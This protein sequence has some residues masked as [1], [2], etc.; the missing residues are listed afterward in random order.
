MPVT[1]PLILLLLYLTSLAHSQQYLPQIG[2]VPWCNLYATDIATSAD[3]TEFWKVDRNGWSTIVSAYP[4]RP[5]TI[6]KITF[7]VVNGGSAAFGVGLLPAPDYLRTQCVGQF[8]NSVSLN[9]FD[10]DKF[11]YGDGIDYTTT[12]T[13]G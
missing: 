6:T 1:T 3:T 2:P 13:N 10:G 12:C 9:P 8:P 5:N 11:I 7:M 4:L